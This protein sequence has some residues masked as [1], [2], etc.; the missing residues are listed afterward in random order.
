MKRVFEN[1][2]AIAIFVVPTILIYFVFVILPVIL[3]FQYSLLDWDGI[4]ASS[5]VGINNYVKLFIGNTDGFTKSIINSF[6]LAFLCVFIQLP[7]ALFLALAISAPKQRGEKF[8][9]TV[10]FMPSIVSAVVI[11]ELWKKIYHPSYG[12]LNT[13]LKAAGLESLTNEWLGNTS[14]ALIAVFIPI[15]W[16]YIGHYMV[17]MYAAIK[18]I[19]DD[20][21]E[22]AR[23]DGANYAKTCLF[24]T[25]PIIRNI[26][27][28]CTVF[29]IAG[30]LKTF[31]LI[32][33]M[34][35]GGPLHSTDV[36]GT[37]MYE[38]IFTKGL[39]GYGSAMAVFIVV[40]CFLITQAVQPLFREKKNDI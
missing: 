18:G 32:Y 12:L 8:F 21:F 27:S 26:L 5:F 6:I 16:Q 14:T 22:A 9:R 36:P 13:L 38:T 39:Y 28:V 3:S 29:A 31:N 30:S 34:T 37:V 7:A 15:V 35:Q 25:I 10:Y 4:G 23:I 2:T 33:V 11:A 40:E 20:V 17:M 1:K 19:P 24:L